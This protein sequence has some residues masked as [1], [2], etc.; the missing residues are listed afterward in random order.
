MQLRN[1]DNL[2]KI[3]AF[4]CCTMMIV[5]SLYCTSNHAKAEDSTTKVT[6]RTEYT[7]IVD[8][9]QEAL[10]SFEKNSQENMYIGAKSQFSKI[11]DTLKDIGANL[12]NE[13]ENLDYKNISDLQSVMYS[14]LPLSITDYIQEL[15]K[16]KQYINSND[17]DNKIRIANLIKDAKAINASI[18]EIS[19]KLKNY[20]EKYSQN[21]TYSDGVELMIDYNGGT[22]DQK[23]SIKVTKI[24]GEEFGLV[25]PSRK[26][27]I[28]SGWK[29][30]SGD[31]KIETK[32]GSNIIIV[33]NETTI[34]QAIW[35][36]ENGE[37]VE[38]TSTVTPTTI[39]TPTIEPTATPTPKQ[40]NVTVTFEGGTY[41]EQNTF[42]QKVIEKNTVVL[43]ENVN[44]IKKDGYRVS[45]IISK[46]GGVCKILDDKRVIY[47]APSYNVTKVDLLTVV[48]EKYDTT[49]ETPEPNAQNTVFVNLNGG[50][51]KDTNKENRIF[52][53]SA[54][55]TKTLFKTTDIKKEGYTLQG[56]NVSDGSKCLIQGEDVILLPTEYK[57][58]GI[59][60]TAI[61]SIDSV[62]TPQPTTTIISV[63]T[64]PT[65]TPIITQGPTIIP[66]M[67]PTQKPTI[68]PTKTPIP[69]KL[70]ISRNTITIGV[71]EGVKILT[72]VIPKT[73]VTFTSQDNLICGVTANG[74]V[75]GRKAGMTQ[76]I[77][78]AGTTTKKVNVNVLLKPTKICL[79]RTFKTKA[80]YTMKKGKTKQLMIYFYQ[81]SY[82]N[83]ITFSSSNKKVATVSSRGKIKA[84]KKG[85][86]KITVKT[87]NGKKAV[88]TIKVK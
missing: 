4:I 18:A 33:G 48:W 52:N 69:V 17:S 42:S 15:E 30:L 47:T 62:I 83:K 58:D 20:L 5:T 38:N 28:F 67:Q 1:K 34:I 66:T 46:N 71:D 9:Y 8:I 49:Q 37:I 36:T 78:K 23:S 44:L 41:K 19:T 32:N 57:R 3:L 25:A 39:N 79:T 72:K 56:F 63:T 45:E 21:K 6:A 82:S 77:V 85:T 53:V 24:P 54:N 27:C 51:F 13:T 75:I 84:K 68:T 60:I 7:Q 64:E 76:I 35:K 50:L 55:T 22:C 43:F 81:N 12:Q 31:S 10:A 2:K 26:D 88:A 74:T 29:I 16:I 61:W 70:E 87:Y 14:V 80:T 59:T 65:A 40:I 73:K 11:D 86:C